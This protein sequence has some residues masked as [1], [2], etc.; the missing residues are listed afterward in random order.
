MSIFK[1][2]FTGLLLYLLSGNFAHGQANIDAAYRA[3]SPVLNPLNP[4]S[5]IQILNLIDDNGQ[6]DN[7]ISENSKLIVSSVDWEELTEENSHFQAIETDTCNYVVYKE[8][9]NDFKI[10]RS[11]A[12]HSKFQILTDDFLKPRIGWSNLYLLNLEHPENL[13][14]VEHFFEFSTKKS[15]LNRLNEQ[16]L[17]SV[18]LKQHKNLVGILDFLDENGC[19]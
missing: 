19:N 12:C 10:Y 13:I 4:W 3:G 15:L 9:K 7:S 16:G 11:L 2:V 5:Y 14:E 1:S 6:K 17:V 8:S 18:D